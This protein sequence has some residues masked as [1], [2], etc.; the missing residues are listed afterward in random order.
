MCNPPAPMSKVTLGDIH[1]IDLFLDAEKRLSENEPGWFTMQNGRWASTWPVID[2]HGVTL[3]SLSFRV[4]PK[5]PDYPSV[6][7]VYGERS[8]CRVDLAPP[9]MI[10]LNP[11]WALGLSPTV[12]G[13]HVHSWR[14]NRDRVLATGVWTLQ[15][16]REVEHAVKRVPQML[17]WFADHI[18]LTLYGSQYGF[19]FKPDRNLFGEG[20]R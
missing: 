19:E 6:S 17:R 20:E 18:N 3:G 9:T 15:A 12:A 5:Y 1:R 4:D 10:K 2:V 14:D 16:R 8:V 11:P 7:L 13:N